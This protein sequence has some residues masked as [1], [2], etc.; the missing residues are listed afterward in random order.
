M[1]NLNTRNTTIDGWRGVS[2][3]LVL[4]GHLGTAIGVNSFLDRYSFALEGVRI[5]FILSGYLITHLLLTRMHT[6]Q[7]ENQPIIKFY[8]R[9][10]LRVL[11][12][13]YTFHLTLL[14]LRHMEIV[15]F[16]D[17]LFLK[18]LLFFT[19]FKFWGGTWILGHIWSLSVE[20]QFYLIWPWLV[21][22]LSFYR[23]KWLC[24]F[25][26][27]LS[28]LVRVANHLY[29][30]YTDLWAGGFFQHADSIAFGALLSVFTITEETKKLEQCPHTILLLLFGAITAGI[31]WFKHHMV[32]GVIT[33]PLYYSFFG[34]FFTL[35]IQ[36]SL[37]LNWPT[38]TAIL[39]N[40]VLGFVGKISFSLYLWQQL[41]LL[42]GHHVGANTSPFFQ[43]VPWNLFWAFLVAVFSY[44]VVE[45]TFLKWKE[46]W[47]L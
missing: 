35:L 41:F 34:L 20:E 13:F 12:A 24:L 16:S 6:E 26:I 42:P 17:L 4:I 10:I 3:I 47:I 43:G 1:L 38:F 40:P 8:L 11:P 27:G 7:K 25:V 32:L 21:Y 44:F 28:P 31:W 14:L 18:N 15:E 29:P 22:G 9:R 45:K 36:A 2:I 23:L 5:F 39:N 46:N 33:V 30:D 37:T 19:N